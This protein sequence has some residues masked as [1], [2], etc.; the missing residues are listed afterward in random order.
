MALLLGTCHSIIVSGNLLLNNSVSIKL[1]FDDFKNNLW[2]L[3]I[4]DIA[5]SLKSPCNILTGISTNFISDLK[6]N[7]RNEII[8]WHPIICQTLLRTTS[9]ENKILK[10]E[11]AWF[12]VTSPQS[13]IEITFNPYIDGKIVSSLMKIDCDVFV[14]ILLQRVK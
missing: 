11:T 5:I 4:N 7:E 8:S 6:F 14:N 3:R 2:Q 13:E 12:Y 9:S 10:F 1:P